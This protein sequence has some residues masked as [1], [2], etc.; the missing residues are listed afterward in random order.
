MLP[1]DTL[2]NISK[3]SAPAWN[4]RLNSS[5]ASFVVP[6]DTKMS[7]LAPVM[8]IVVIYQGEHAV[9]AK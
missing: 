2:L 6:A 9:R 4:L 1:P 7:P 8:F 5:R 3:Q